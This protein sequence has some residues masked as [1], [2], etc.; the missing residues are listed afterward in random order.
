[1]KKMSK[2]SRI[3][4]LVLA[5]LM[6]FTACNKAPVEDT[7]PKETDKKPAETQAPVATPYWELLDS[8]D[9]T[10]DLPDWEG[11]V[12]EVKIWNAGG[13]SQVI[14][15]I[16]ATDVVYKEIE[17]VTGI[18]F[19]AEESYDNGGNTVDAKL[20]MVIA[21]NDLP[22]IIMGYNI[23]KQFNELY[24]N[25][26]LADLTKYYEDGSLDQ[27]LK[28]FPLE[29]MAGP[30]YTKATAS[31]GA[32]YLIPYATGLAAVANVFNATGYY[33]DAY[34]PAHFSTYGSV[35]NSATAKTTDNAIFVREDILQA[36][37]PNTL[38]IEELHNI[39]LENG[40]FTKEQ[41]F[42][43]GMKSSDDFWSFLYDIKE[44]IATGEYLDSNGNP[45][46]V[47]AG[48][49]TETDNWA[50]MTILP[51]LVD[52]IPGGTDYFVSA[53]RTATD[54]NLLEYAF[55]SDYYTGLMKDLNG[56]VRDD[57]IAQNSLLDNGA[58]FT[59]KCMASHYAVLYGAQFIPY[60]NEIEGYR[61]IWI[62]TDYNADFGGF[63]T[64]DFI[65]YY[66]I[67][68]ADLS[69]EQLDQLVHCINYLNSDVGINN[70]FY[71]P[72]TAGLFTVDADGNRTYSTA[73]L[74]NRFMKG[75]ANGIDK[76]YGL[77]DNYATDP[78]FRLVPK[79]IGT[80]LLDPGY[81]RAAEKGRDERYATACRYFNPGTLNGY[82]L[83]EHATYV[84]SGC[85]AY[86]AL[87]QQIDGMKQFWSARTG[88]ENQIKKVIVAESDAEFE[89]QYNELL[90]Y[91]LENG[92]TDETLKAFNDLWVATNE[93]QL[94]EAG[95]LK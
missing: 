59:Q 74:E 43:T 94:K 47:M 4:A 53:D 75:E 56:L 45:M 25:G 14:G 85:E 10:S 27:L 71:G 5:L 91:T 48:P 6:V 1:M 70:F 69:D 18:R 82:T 20:P 44:L 29:E 23:D 83:G 68:K 38:T 77:L 80:Y 26:Y 34:D 61:P 21:S 88:F 95:L 2:L 76:Q 40:R 72:E 37:L 73:V 42:D 33:P 8:V 51:G 81:I 54:G 3:F 32:K 66:G 49:H 63:S 90:S 50:W 46:E 79:G 52:G 9:D 93:Q 11:D 78:G 39:Y 92:L 65:Y 64:Y 31:D 84:K 24:D 87:A 13:T 41:I 17:R 35:P 89:K 28:Y 7:T 62:E 19:N 55:S 16:A 12:L 67:F 57:V 86:G 22:T 36:L 58:A 30:V 60:Y 15:D